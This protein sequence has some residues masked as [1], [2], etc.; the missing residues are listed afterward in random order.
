MKDPPVHVFSVDLEEYFQVAAFE[1]HVPRES[2]DDLPERVVAVTDRLLGL[3]DEFGVTATFFTLGWI[4]ERHPKLV[5]RVAA[6][7]HEIASHGWWHRRITRC[8]P[9][10]LRAEVVDSRRIL[11][12][13]TG[14]RVY[15]YRAPSFSLV[16]GAEWAF[17]VLIEA[18]YTYD[19]SI[20][21][22]HRGD[23]G[24]PGV[25]PE[26]HYVERPAGRILEIPL[27]TTTLAGWRVPAAGGGYFRL[28][29]YGLTARAFDQRVEDGRPGMFYIH[30]WELDPEQPSFDVAWPT[31]VRHYGG[32]ERTLPRLRRLLG[33]YRFGSVAQLFP[34]ATDVA[35]TAGAA[36]PRTI[37][38]GA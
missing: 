11:E 31:R 19:S 1:K 2:W 3:L 20:F 35:N 32:L 36:P 8:T 21:P 22:V 18:G 26:P 13:V 12:D 16:P 4:A 34:G 25:D 23:Y 29:P 28:L 6:A 17:D 33:S 10:E 30:P 38:A 9:D 24:Y 14:A 15:G 7:G 27:T 37:P 5:R